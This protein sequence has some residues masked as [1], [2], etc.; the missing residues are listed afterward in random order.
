[1]I[2]GIS[3]YPSRDSTNIL[4]FVSTID[5]F[6]CRYL[7]LDK[8]IPS[9]SEIGAILAEA[10]MEALEGFKSDNK[11]YPQRIIYFRYGLNEGQSDTVMQDEVMP[12]MRTLDQMSISGTLPIVPKIAYVTV[13]KQ[14]NSRFYTKFGKRISN[15]PMGT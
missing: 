13:N 14:I 11:F 7:N 2:V 3:T 4:G 9:G 10:M 1:M 5:H 15:P 6:F 12:I 8:Q